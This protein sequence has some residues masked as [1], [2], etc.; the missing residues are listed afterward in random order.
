[1]QEAA[2]VPGM[3]TEDMSKIV[4][5]AIQGRYGEGGA[6][7]TWLMLKEQNPSL[8]PRLYVKVQQLVES[9]RIEFK[10]SQNKLIDIKR[11]YETERNSLVSGFWLR[12]AGYPKIDLNTIKIITTDRVEDT[13][14]KGR[15]ASP[16][17]LR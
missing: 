1:V 4:K 10:N 8:D 2:Q 17:K 14:Q 15:E 3:M 7:A 9:Y 5:E 13:Y 12:L 6:K 16:L 11:Q